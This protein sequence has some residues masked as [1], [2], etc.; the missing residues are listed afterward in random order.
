MWQLTYILRNDKLMN[1]MLEPFAF[2]P[3]ADDT[4]CYG[5]GLQGVESIGPPFALFANASHTGT[6]SCGKE[7]CDVW[8]QHAEYSYPDPLDGVH[9]V[10]VSAS[11]LARATTA[12]IREARQTL[13]RCG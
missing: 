3:N 6:A 11:E 13:S 1:Y 2:A 5:F 8:K 10:S 4:L 9:N 12:G 7:T